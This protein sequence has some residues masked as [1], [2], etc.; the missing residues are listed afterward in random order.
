VRRWLLVML[1]LLTY[2]LSRGWALESLPLHNDEGLHLTRA[3]QVWD[4]HPFWQINDGK[5]VNH[6]LIALFYPQNAPVFAGRIATV[7]VGALGLAASYALAGRLAGPTAAWLAGILWLGCPYL[8]FYERMAL[9]DAEAGALALVTLW[10]GVRLAQR[11]RARDAALTGIALATAALFKFTA[12]PFAVVVALVVA[13]TGRVPRQKRLIN[14]VIIAAVVLVCFAVPL[15]YLYTRNG[16]FDVALGW[17]GQP[18]DRSAATENAM[19]LWTQLTD[20]GPPIWSAL[21]LIGLAAFLAVRPAPATGLARLGRWSNVV[22]LLAG[23]L[24]VAAITLLGTEALPRH[25]VVGLPTALTLAGAGLGTTLERGTSRQG[26]RAA[27]GTLMVILAASMLPFAWT[28]YRDPGELP[29]PAQVRGQYITDHSAGFGLREAVLNFPQT[30]TQSDAL[31]VASMFPDSCRRANFYAA[32]SYTML[33]TDAPGLPVIE[34]ALV[35]HGAV[36]VLVE[37]PPIGV[38]IRTLNAHA[39]RVAG[40][41]RPGETEATASVTLW[42][43]ERL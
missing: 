37:Q 11:G 10:A 24:P 29:L 21:T 42:R 4:L 15:L 3:V 1:L 32:R 7:L 12:A 22:L 43:L 23:L 16:N 39:T 28:A 25:Y 9:S 33:C 13:L 20:F 26:R 14:L 40:Y 19:R 30:I 6:W 18:G 35:E 2:W 27:V 31:I 36:Y 38:D 17:I 5:I 8:F 41:P 34:S